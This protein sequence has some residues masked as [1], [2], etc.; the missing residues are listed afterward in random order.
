MSF[1]RLPLDPLLAVVASG[2]TKST[3]GISMP[4][5]IRRGTPTS[6]NGD[7]AGGFNLA[8]GC[9]VDQ[10]NAVYVIDTVNTRIRKYTDDNDGAQVASI[11]VSGTDSYACEVDQATNRVYIAGYTSGVLRWY[12]Y[13]LTGQLGSFAVPTTVCDIVV[14]PNG[15]LLLFFDGSPFRMDEYT[16]AGVFVASWHTGSVSN[17]AVRGW[18]DGT[19]VYAGFYSTYGVPPNRGVRRF[20]IA[21]RGATNSNHMPG[22]FQPANGVQDLPWPKDGP[23]KVSDYTPRV[24]GVLNGKLIYTLNSFDTGQGIFEADPATGGFERLLVARTMDL[25][26]WPIHYGGYLAHGAIS[27]TKVWMTTFSQHTLH[28]FDHRTATAQW[29]D[30]G[31]YCSLNTSGAKF[32]GI[33]VKGHDASKVK[34]QYR[35]NLG[36][37]TD[38]VPSDDFLSGGSGLDFSSPNRVDL[39]CQQNTWRGFGA[40]TSAPFDKTPPLTKPL[41]QFEDGHTTPSGISATLAGTLEGVAEIGG[42]LGA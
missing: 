4:G 2:A 33:E 25:S 23:Q 13:G 10:F 30:I 26:G 36:T 5:V 42:Q 18:H 9:A 35:Y 20:L 15:N 41:L 31:Q 14:L 7:P 40:G 16:T 17:R 32:L 38:I 28:G 3:S 27:G 37:W 22:T 21:D 12:D 1:K 6:P 8:S 34:W 39:L 24:I 29:D 11:N 19:Y